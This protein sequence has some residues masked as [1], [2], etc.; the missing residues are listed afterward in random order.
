MLKFDFIN[1]NARSIKVGIFL[2][3]LLTCVTFT[4][5][6]LQSDM[7]VQ[8]PITKSH[9]LIETGNYYDA[10][11]ALKPLLTSDQKSD[12]QEE[13]LWLA[14]QLGDKVTGMIDSELQA[15]FHLMVKEGNTDSAHRTETKAFQERV[16][17]LNEL[18]A[19]IYDYAEMRGRHYDKGFLQRLIDE[20]PNTLKR[21]FAEYELIFTGEGVPRSGVPEDTLKTLYVYIDKYEKT[22]RVEVYRAYLDIA[23]LHHGLWAVLTYPD[24]PGP[25]GGMGEGYTSAAPE[26][27]KKR[28]AAHRAKALKYYA[29]YHLNPHKLPDDE[30][31]ERLKKNEAFGWYFIVW[32]C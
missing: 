15:N 19:C 24:E 7:D 22:G 12:A 10:L 32:G 3:L 21:P 9:K 27:D 8:T 25:G 6:H 23:H 20:Y 29:L 30:S 4:L 18:G 13:A 5:R 26:K 11:L 17:P 31:Y 1:R 14:H 28:A 2:I 16:K